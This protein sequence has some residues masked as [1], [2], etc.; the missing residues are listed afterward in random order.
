MVMSLRRP[1]YLALGDFCLLGGIYYEVLSMLN[2]FLKTELKDRR[3]MK[4]NAAYMH[5]RVPDMY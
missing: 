4:M 5:K 3:W 1:L 2:L